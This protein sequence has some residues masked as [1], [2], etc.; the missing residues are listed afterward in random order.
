MIRF[1]LDKLLKLSKGDSTAILK[2]LKEYY[3]AKKQKTLP[4]YALSGQSWIIN[5]EPLFYKHE[6]D[7][8]FRVQYILLAAR[9]DYYLYRTYGTKSLI[10]SYFPDLEIDKIKHNP[11]LII[12]KTE[13]KFKYEG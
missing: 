6:V 3:E 11:L 13:I 12:T 2:N 1:N 4:K 5:P 7:I 8:G 9:R 10:L